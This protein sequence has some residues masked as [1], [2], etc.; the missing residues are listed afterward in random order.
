MSPPASLRHIAFRFGRSQSAFFC[1]AFE[2]SFATVSDFPGGIFA[3]FADVVPVFNALSASALAF[4][5][6]RN[7]FLL[8]VSV[9]ISTPDRLHDPNSSPHIRPSQSLPSVARWKLPSHTPNVHRHWYARKAAL[10][11]RL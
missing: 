11:L 2:S 6:C 10:P 8:V 3:D 1:S 4:G 9:T 5:E 7:D